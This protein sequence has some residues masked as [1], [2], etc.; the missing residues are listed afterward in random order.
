MTRHHQVPCKSAQLC[1]VLLCNEKLREKDRDIIIVFVTTS[2]DF[3]MQAFSVHAFH[4]I[5]KPYKAEQIYKVLDD[6]SSYVSDNSKY[7]N[8]ITVF[9]TKLFSHGNAVHFLHKNIYKG[10]FVGVFLE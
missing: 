5:T 10:Y 3:M 6:A 9:F 1:R 7:N 8:N 4:Y 2:P